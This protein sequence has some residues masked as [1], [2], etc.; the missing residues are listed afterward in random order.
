MAATVVLKIGKK[1]PTVINMLL[2]LHLISQTEVISMKLSNKSNLESKI[3]IFE[4]IKNTFKKKLRKINKKVTLN[5]AKD[6]GDE[7]KLSYHKISFEKLKLSIIK[8][9]NNRNK[10]VKKG[11]GESLLYSYRCKIFCRR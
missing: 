10:L 4:F 2:I 8:K 7:K 6:I 3:D 11:F 5:K 1:Y 9:L